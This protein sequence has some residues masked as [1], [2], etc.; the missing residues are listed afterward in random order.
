MVYRARGEFA[1]AG[2]KIAFPPIGFYDAKG[3]WIYYGS[4]VTKEGM[5][6]SSA[7]TPDIYFDERLISGAWPPADMGIPHTIITAWETD[8]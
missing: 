1:R 3:N 7:G 5:V 2:A 6:T 4:V 8:L